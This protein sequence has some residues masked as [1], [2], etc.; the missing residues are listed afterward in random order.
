[1]ELIATIRGR[2]V[3]IFF[4]HDLTR[5]VAFLQTGVYYDAPWAPAALFPDVP[6]EEVQATLQKIQAAPPAREEAE[7]PAADAGEPEV[8]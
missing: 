8:P 7:M 1:L 3:P 6:V 2:G 4:E 5:L